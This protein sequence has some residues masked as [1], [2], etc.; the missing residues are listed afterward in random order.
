MQDRDLIQ[1]GPKKQSGD[2][3]GKLNLNKHNENLLAM[4]G[5]FFFT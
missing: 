5:Y 1:P 2:S 4:Q 3:A